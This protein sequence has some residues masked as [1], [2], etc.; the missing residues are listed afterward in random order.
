MSMRDG[1]PVR[2]DRLKGLSQ[3]M[4]LS[5]VSRDPGGPAAYDEAL[6]RDVIEACPDLLPTHEI[7]LAFK[8]MRPICIELPVRAPGQRDRTGYLDNLLINRDGKICLVEC[9]LWRNPE[10]ARKVVAQLL[11]YAAGLS[12]WSYASLKEAVTRRV[13]GSVPDPIAD[14]VLGPSASEEDKAEFALAVE[15]SLRR[16]SFLL[17]IAGDAIRPEVRDIVRLLQGQP[18]AS[19]VMALVEFGIYASQDG[20]APYF[21][22][23]RLLVPEGLG[24]RA[25]DPVTPALLAEALKELPPSASAL[26]PTEESFMQRLAGAS[27]TLPG[28][29]GHF[30]TACRMAGC[31]PELRKK[32]VL[33][34]DVP[35]LRPINAGTISH[36]GA[37]EFWGQ[38]SRDEQLGEPIGRRY[39]ERIVRLLPG[40]ALK[41]ESPEPLN[42]HV[43]YNNRSEV[44]LTVM[45]EHER[46]WLSAI[47]DLVGSLHA[48]EAVSP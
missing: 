23:P 5:R 38:A 26:Q 9:K 48:A 30:L 37:V 43:R 34:V 1:T 12:S 3:A 16:G 28:R 2:V 25:G 40:A 27:P 24:P 22:Q 8:D 13:R 33:Y 20:L 39:I 10:A 47:E 11:D 17:L 4:P 45:L 31:R 44:P 29:L 41:D 18:M 6:I 15:R 36:N 42:W 7:D 19:F 14:R 46:E 32:Y 21:I 35:G